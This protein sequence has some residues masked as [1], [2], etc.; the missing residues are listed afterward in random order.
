VIAENI[1]TLHSAFISTTVLKIMHCDISMAIYYIVYSNLCWSIVQ[2][3]HRVSIM[4]VFGSIEHNV[5][6]DNFK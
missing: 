3:K 1:L 2:R 5:A 4:T 6:S